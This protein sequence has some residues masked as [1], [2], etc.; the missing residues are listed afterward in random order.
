V[1][2]EFSE[3]RLE[4]ILRSSGEGRLGFITTQC[5]YGNFGFYTS[6]S[7]PGFDTLLL[8]LHKADKLSGLLAAKGN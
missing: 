8:P 4:D 1:E 5:S 6:H 2:E 7:N 3:L